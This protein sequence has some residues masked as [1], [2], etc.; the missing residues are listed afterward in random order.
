MSKKRASVSLKE[1]LRVTVAEREKFLTPQNAADELGM[2]LGS[3]RQRL[4]KE[5]KSYPEIYDS[6]KR[7]HGSNGRKRATL[8]EA[9]KMLE[10]IQGGG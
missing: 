3:F 7:Y 10:S 2:T 9:M 8:S 5:R 6:V 1:F 4:S